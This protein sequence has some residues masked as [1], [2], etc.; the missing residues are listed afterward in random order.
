MTIGAV[1]ANFAINPGG[2]QRPE[3]QDME[4]LQSALKSGDLLGAQQTFA[5]FKQDFHAAHHGQA[6]WQTAVPD[7]LKQ[8]LQGLQSALKSGDLAGAQQAFAQFKTDFQNLQQARRE[9]PVS[10]GG[11]T[12]EATGNINILA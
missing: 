6:L 11:P 5:Q 2:H 12:P 1:G 10:G 9:P 4:A 7:A 3:R 8:D